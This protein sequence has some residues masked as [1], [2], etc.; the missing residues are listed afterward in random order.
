MHKITI[1]LSLSELEYLDDFIHEH[2]VSDD[3]TEY[4]TFKIDLFAR[5]CDLCEEALEN[6]LKNEAQLQF[7]LGE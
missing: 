1:E 3:M 5:I 2:A 7:D 4:G 6:D